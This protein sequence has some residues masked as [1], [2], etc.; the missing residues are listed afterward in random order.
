M[1]VRRVLEYLNPL[2]VPIALWPCDRN[3]ATKGVIREGI[4][5]LQ[6]GLPENPVIAETSALAA[7]LEI[8]G[9]VP[10]PRSYYAGFHGTERCV[11]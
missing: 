6:T 11:D 4:Q 5:A 9:N 10:N 2:N 7:L 3:L 1:L 8:G